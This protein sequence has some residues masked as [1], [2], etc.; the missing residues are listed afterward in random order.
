MKFFVYWNKCHPSN[1]CSDWCFFPFCAFRLIGPWW[2]RTSL[3]IF[4]L[5]FFLDVSLPTHLYRRHFMESVIIWQHM[6]SIFLFLTIA[7]TFISTG[8]IVKTNNE[9]IEMWLT[10]TFRIVFNSSYVNMINYFSYMIRI[11]TN[12]F[13]FLHISF[14]LEKEL[15][16]TKRHLIVLENEWFH[17]NCCDA[18]ILSTEYLVRHQHTILNLM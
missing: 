14:L 6:I 11:F 17:L 10:Q 5:S 16:V 8:H 15:I 12:V 7:L 3:D 13:V 2:P 9:Y 18:T 1:T 4:F